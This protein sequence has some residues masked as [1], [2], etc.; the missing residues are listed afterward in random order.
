MLTIRDSQMN[1]MAGTSGKAPVQPCPKEK[2]WIE[3]RMVDEDGK[4]VEGV[5]Y[6]VKLPDGSLKEGSLDGEG[7]ARFEDIDP[8]SAEISFLEVDGGEWGP[9]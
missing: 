7:K 2:T 4:P 8:G 5:K 1:D 9:A 3:F 6:R